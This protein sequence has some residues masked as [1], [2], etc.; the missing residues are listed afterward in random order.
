MGFFEFYLNST[1]N[2]C[3]CFF[4]FSFLEQV[5]WLRLSASD[6]TFPVDIHGK[7]SNKHFPMTVNFWYCIWLVLLKFTTW[8]YILTK[9]FQ[10]LKLFELICWNEKLLWR[11]FHCH[12][13]KFATK[14]IVIAKQ[15]TWL[16]LIIWMAMLFKHCSGIFFSLPL[17]L[18][19]CLSS[20]LSVCLSSCRSHTWVR[21]KI[22]GF[23]EN[24]T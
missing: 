9:T 18:S 20:C 5:N 2:Y 17:C 15:N 24:N 13:I 21:R 19:V 7:Q 4:F 6:M 22:K 8:K 3:L 14:Y 10:R 1:V 12:I 16:S 23:H 11:L